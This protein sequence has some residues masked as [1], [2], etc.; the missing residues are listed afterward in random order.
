MEMMLNLLGAEE[1]GFLFTELFLQH[2]PPQVRTALTGARIDDPR[3]L[4]KE[5]DRFFLAPRATTD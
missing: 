4:A 1:P 2:V 5:G 3:V